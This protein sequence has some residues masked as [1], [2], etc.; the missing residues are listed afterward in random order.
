[1]YQHTHIHTL[2]HTESRAGSTG[3]LGADSS[4]YACEWS[5][6]GCTFFGSFDEVVRHEVTCKQMLKLKFAGSTSIPGRA[7]SST[8]ACEW[9]CKFFGSFDEVVRHEATCKFEVN[10]AL[11]IHS[12]PNYFHTFIRTYCGV[13]FLRNRGR[14]QGKELSRAGARARHTHTH[15]HT[16]KM[17]MSDA[18]ISNF[19]PRVFVSV[20]ICA[21]TL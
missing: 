7:N 3:I 11:C 5:G 19:M 14:S 18:S 17:H 16:H 13:L 10:N 4:A 9:G 8:H 1:M 2:K 20:H 15:T 21:R 12:L 6:W